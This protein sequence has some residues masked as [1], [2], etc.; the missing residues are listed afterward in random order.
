MMDRDM[1]WRSVCYYNKDGRWLK[2]CRISEPQKIGE[3]KDLE[4]KLKN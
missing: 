3:K 1:H 4:K 2:K